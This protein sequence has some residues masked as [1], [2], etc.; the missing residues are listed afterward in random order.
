M[1]LLLHKLGLQNLGDFA[2]L[3]LAGLASRFGE[4][5]LTAYKVLNEGFEPPWP[6]LVLP[7][8]VVEEEDLES[9]ELF[10]PVETLEPLLFLLR[11][12]VDRVVARLHGRNERAVSVQLDFESHRSALGSALQ[13]HKREWEFGFPV[14]QKSFNTIFPILKEKLFF[15]LQRR[16]L[17]APVTLMRLSILETAPGSARQRDFFHN[18][19]HEQEVWSSLVARLCQKLGEEHVFGAEVLSRHRPESAWR[20]HLSEPARG[21][22][23]ERGDPQAPDGPRTGPDMRAGSGA[24][25]VARAGLGAGPAAE[26]GTVTPVN[27]ALAGLPNRPTRLLSKPRLLD[28]DGDW[29]SDFELRKRWKV[30]DWDGPE[31]IS[32]EWWSEHK[33]ERDYYR[34]LTDNGE[35]L[36]LFL[37]KEGV[38]LHG[39][40]D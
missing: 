20:G 15:D 38:Y 19:E 36:W 5:A 7:E 32:G 23:Q 1:S 34:V 35:Q 14:P 9:R 33:F 13:I 3:P 25:A 8:K 39:F 24:R 21:D 12:L 6:P 17:E 40:F 16:P 18:R 11:A 27:F 29:L 2:K 28:Q 30:I 4:E 10:V 26:A 22:P 37:A 31:R